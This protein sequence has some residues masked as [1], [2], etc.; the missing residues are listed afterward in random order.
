MGLLYLTILRT[1]RVKV[2]R[3]ISR[4]HTSVTSSTTKFPNGCSHADPRRLLELGYCLPN[5]NARVKKF[6]KL[7]RKLAFSLRG[8]GR[9]VSYVLFGNYRG[10][11]TSAQKGACCL[12]PSENT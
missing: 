5:S 12:R 8:E 1:E 7:L 10:L 2:G 6:T 11:L 4:L 3:A 9:G